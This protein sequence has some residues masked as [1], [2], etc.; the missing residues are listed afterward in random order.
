PPSAQSSRRSGQAYPRRS[1]EPPRNPERPA[2]HKHHHNLLTR[3]PRPAPKA[4]SSQHEKPRNTTRP[5]HTAT[6]LATAETPHPPPRT[7]GNCG[8]PPPGRTI[9]TTPSATVNR[10]NGRSSALPTVSLLVAGLQRAIQLG[11]AGRGRQEMR[12]ILG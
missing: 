4:P 10:Q 7:S 9:I 8:R 2:S 6:T 5:P 11:G 3:S 12:R 1:P